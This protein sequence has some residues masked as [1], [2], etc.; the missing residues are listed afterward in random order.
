MTSSAEKIRCTSDTDFYE[1]LLNNRDIKRTNEQLA[2][3]E[4]STPTSIRPVLATSVA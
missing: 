2:R 1:S 4:A 3:M